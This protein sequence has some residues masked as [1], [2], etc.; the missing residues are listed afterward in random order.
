MKIRTMILAAAISALTVSGFA[1]GMKAK[2]PKK[3]KHV[4]TSKMALKKPAKAVAHKVKAAKVVKKGG[5][6]KKGK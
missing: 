5:M 6:V 4:A 3:A 2:T 1:Q